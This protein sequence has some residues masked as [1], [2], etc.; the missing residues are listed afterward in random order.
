MNFKR[1]FV[2]VAQKVA[3]PVNVK[4]QAY[5]S[6]RD[7]FRK[8]ADEE[9]MRAMELGKTRKKEDYREAKRRYY[10]ERY[11][12]SKP[13][14]SGAS[15]SRKKS[16]SGSAKTKA[17]SSK[18]KSATRKTST[19][20]VKTKKPAAKTSRKTNKRKQPSQAKKRTKERSSTSN[21][22]QGMDFFLTGNKI[23]DPFRW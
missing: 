3:V 2:S 19:S 7:E 12:V 1:K 6:E 4:Y 23:S 16:S 22:S 15:S 9:K 20:T 13:E 5:K 8:I 10:E 21:A 14:P 11:G 17:K 18:S